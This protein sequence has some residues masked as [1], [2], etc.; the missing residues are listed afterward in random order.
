MEIVALQVGGCNS[1]FPRFP[2]LTLRLRLTGWS[3]TNPGIIHCHSAFLLRVLFGLETTA[4]GVVQYKPWNY[5][6]SFS[7]LGPGIIWPWDYGWRGGPIQ[8]LG[9]STVI[10]HS[11]PGYYLALRLRLTGWSNTN[12][13]IIYC[14]SAFLPRVLFGLETTADGVVQYKPWDYPL[15][16]SILAPGIIWPWDYGWRGGPIQTLELSTVIQHSCPGY[17]LALRLRLTGWSN[18]NP[19]IIHCHSAFLPRVLFDLETTADGVVHNK[20]WNYLLS[21]SIL[22]PG[23]IWPWDYGWRCS[24]IQTLE[25]FTVIQHSC[26]WYYLALRLW[27]TGWSNTNPGIIYSHSAFLARVLFGLETTADRVVQYKPWDYPLSFSIL[28]P[29]IIWPWDYGW[30]GGPIQTLGLSTVIQHSCPGYYLALR[31][32]LTGWSNTNPGIIYCHSAFLAR[33]LFDL[34]TMADG[35]VQYKPWDYPLSFSILGPGI[36]WPWDYGWRGGPIQTLELSTVIQHSCPGYYY[37]ALR[38]WLTGWSNTNPGIIHCHSA[39]LARVLFG[40]ETTADGVVQYK[41]WNYPL[42]FS[43]LAPGIIWPWDYGWQ[44]GPIQ[45]LEL[46]TVIQHSWPGYYLAL[47]L[48]LTGWSNTNPGI[49]HCHSAFLPRVVL[50]GQ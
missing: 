7:I 43:I 37:L 27:L 24:P 17:Y 5:P 10:Q 30:Q 8:T 19:G 44:G 38:L 33:V 34:E 23:I 36:I 11:W 6:L 25:L 48:R 15:S 3:N 16:F 47:R 41:P 26:A 45:T 1:F 28:A 31:L 32:R 49:I 29:G 42:S 40:L 18:T 2:I 39:F 4:D 35:V 9:L 21:F 46:S 12:P 20:P 22:G 14:H 50:C 13:G